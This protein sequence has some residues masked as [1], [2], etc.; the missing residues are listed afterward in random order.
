MLN[1]KLKFKVLVSH[2]GGT[3]AALEGPKD[4]HMV[5]FVCVML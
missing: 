5:R 2:R 4:E 1:K 3:V